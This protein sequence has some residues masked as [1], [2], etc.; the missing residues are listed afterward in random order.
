VIRACIWFWVWALAGALTGFAFLVGGFLWGPPVVLCICLLALVWRAPVWPHTLGL[1]TGLGVAPVT[2]AVIQL[3]DGGL[4]PRPWAA[5]G[6]VLVAVGAFG[7]RLLGGPR[8]E[9][10]VVR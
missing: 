6:L 7:F 10:L 9:R 5:V 4:D 2:V 1:S 3:Y 8:L